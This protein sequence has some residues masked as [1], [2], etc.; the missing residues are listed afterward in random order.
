MEEEKQK[1]KNRPVLFELDIN[2]LCWFCDITDRNP[3]ATIVSTLSQVEGDRI[4]NVIQ[5]NSP[6]PKKDIE[7]MK[8]HPL[9]KSVQVLTMS[10]SSALLVVVSSYKAMT[11]KL[12]HHTN[13]KMLES[14]VTRAGVDSEILMAPSDKEMRELI[15]RFSEHKD[16]ADVKLKKKKYLNPEDA[17]SLSA[18]RTSGF[19]DLQSAKQL[20]TPKQLEIFQLACD[21]GYYDIPKKISIEELAEKTGLSPSTLAEHLRKAE[22]K[23]LPVFWKVMKKL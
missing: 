11:Y 5:L 4:T 1:P 9:V 7:R 15:T 3:D 20:I 18:F 22:A 19:F 17:V 2:H 12:L 23:L 16:Y 8:A 10:Q 6:D 13:V 14:P 21:Y